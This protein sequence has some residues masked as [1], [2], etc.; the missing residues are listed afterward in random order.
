MRL[1]HPLNRLSARKPLSNYERNV[2]R[3]LNPPS[4]SLRDRI[5]GVVFAVEEFWCR[6]VTQRELYRRLDDLRD[7]VQASLPAGWDTPSKAECDLQ[8]IRD[9]VAAQ[10]RRHAREF[11]TNLPHEADHDSALP[12][13]PA[14]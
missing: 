9:A 11:M 2:Q 4:P 3:F 12:E 5:G 1:P 13:R 8:R 10:R 14:V 6:H 7:Q